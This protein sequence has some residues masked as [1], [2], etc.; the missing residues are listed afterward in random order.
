MENAAYRVEQY[1]NEEAAR[2]MVSMQQGGARQYELHIGPIKE[3]T[4]RRKNAGTRV[5][6][7]LQPNHKRSYTVYQNIRS[8]IGDDVYLYSEAWSM[9][10]KGAQY[11]FFS[12]PEDLR[13]E[14]YVSHADTWIEPGGIDPSYQ[15]GK[16]HDAESPW[17]AAHGR[18][19]LRRP[20]VGAIVTTRT[21]KL[22]WKDGVLQKPF[23]LRAERYQA[24][25][26]GERVEVRGLGASR[27]KRY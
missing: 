27:R 25:L 9:G 3:L 4:G 13:G 10:A 7:R 26:E 6:L 20:P 18:W 2:Q 11:D 24:P 1:E 5:L 12:V 14:A 16:P 17:G 23:E 8:R 19:E 15:P 22:R 21:T